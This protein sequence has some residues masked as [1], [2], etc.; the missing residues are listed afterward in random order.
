LRQNWVPSSSVIASMLTAWRRCFT[1]G[2][3]WFGASQP[4]FVEQPEACGVERRRMRCY[5]HVPCALAQQLHRRGAEPR[6]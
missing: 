3:R 2:G 4:A 5:D 6:L 1:C